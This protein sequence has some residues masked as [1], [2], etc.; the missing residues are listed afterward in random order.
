MYIRVNAQDNV[1]IIVEPEGVASGQVLDQG[2]TAREAIPQANKIALVSFEPGQPVLRYGHTIG[3]AERAIP[4]GSWV[5]EDMIRMPEPVSLDDL[6]LATAVP[7]PPEPLEGHTFEGFRNPDGSVGTRN[8]LAIATTVQCVAPTVEYAVRRIKTELLPKFPNVD[9][10]VAVTHSYGCGVAIDAPGAAIPI[11]TLKH[12]S[13]H[14]N[15]AGNPMVVSL[16]CE[17]MQ[18][19]RLLENALPMLS[20]RFS[21]ACCWRTTRMTGGDHRAWSADSP[22]T[23]PCTWYAGGTRPAGSF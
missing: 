2:I 12:I 11:R 9:D 3:F 10:A 18:P 15:A 5:R 8:I 20:E 16:G 13:L 19:A 1:A 14:A 21:V 17:K 22:R 7:P 23:G 6:P 4:A